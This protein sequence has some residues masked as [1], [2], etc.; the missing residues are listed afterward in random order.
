MK[1]PISRFSRRLVLQDISGES[2]GISPHQGLPTK[3]AVSQS[4]CQ[5]YAH[6]CT[7]ILQEKPWDLFLANTW[8][9]EVISCTLLWGYKPCY[10]TNLQHLL[11]QTQ[12]SCLAPKA[13]PA[14]GLQGGGL[15]A[16][17][18]FSCLQEG[19]I[20]HGRLAPQSFPSELSIIFSTWSN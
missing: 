14:P 20:Q 1:I 18:R 9:P 4:F 15:G 16:G 13:A 10:A 19:C 8:S 3:A 5:S 17:C 6:A 11:C 2:L 12:Q 7:E